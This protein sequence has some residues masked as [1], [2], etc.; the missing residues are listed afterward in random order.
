MVKLQ[1]Q[2]QSS[3]SGL[4]TGY[5]KLAKRFYRPFKILDKIGPAAYKLQLPEGARIHPMFHCS[6]LK[7]FCQPPS[8][9]NVAPLTLSLHWLLWA[10]KET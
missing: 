8:N 2:R 4:H 3:V 1:P 9:D 10:L 6:M 5:S 7:P